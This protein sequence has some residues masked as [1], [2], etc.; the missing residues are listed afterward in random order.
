MNFLL[1]PW[2]VQCVLPHPPIRERD[3]HVRIKIRLV[4]QVQVAN[5]KIHPSVAGHPSEGAPRSTPPA[6][7]LVLFC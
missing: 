3:K 4:I 5:P 1:V 6:A 7:C 2:Q